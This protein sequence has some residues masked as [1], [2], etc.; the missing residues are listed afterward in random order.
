VRVVWLFPI[1]VLGSCAEPGPAP[2]GPETFGREAPPTP[3]APPAASAPPTATTARPAPD[4]GAPP[5]SR[6]PNAL[7]PT[8]ADAGAAEGDARDE[9]PRTRALRRIATAAQTCHARHTPGVAGKLVLRLLRDREGKVESASL[10]AESSTRALLDAKLERCVLDAAKA[11]RLPSPDSEEESE[12]QIPL[13][14]NP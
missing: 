12:I 8:V 10:I 7:A 4:A 5:P 3:G 13:S 6:T 1:V 9:D 14:F 11:E 2:R